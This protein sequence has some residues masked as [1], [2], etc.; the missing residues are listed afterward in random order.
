MIRSTTPF[1]LWTAP[2]EEFS[3]AAGNDGPTRLRTAD[4]GTERRADT[5]LLQVSIVGHACGEVAGS[6]DVAL[7]RIS[8]SCNSI[9][10]R[11]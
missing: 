6:T 4:R 1:P 10:R 5:G 11:I 8:E 7:S 2:N 3:S 9:Y